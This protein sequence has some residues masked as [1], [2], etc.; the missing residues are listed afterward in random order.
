M[1]LLQFDQRR[2]FCLT[3]DLSEE[4]LSSHPYAILSHTWGEDD[5]EVSF[6]DL[7][8][9]LGDTKVGYEKLRFC[10][11]QAKK[12]SLRYFWVDTC[13]IDKSSSAELSKAITSMFRWYGGAV[14]CYVYLRDVST[15]NFGS[16]NPLARSWEPA[17]RNSRWFQRGW[18]LQELLA[19]QSVEF[20][21]SH[22]TRLGDKESLEKVLHEV[23]KIPPRALRNAPLDE[24][25]VEE[26]M[27]WAEGRKT[28]HG[29]DKPY[30]LLG[31]FGVSMLPN[32]GEG[33]DRALARLQKEIQGEDFIARLPYAQDAP[34]NSITSQH[35]ATCLANTRVDLLNRIYK[36]AD[37]EGEQYI[38]WLSGLAGTG[39]TTIARSVS[40][41]YDTRQHLGASFFFSRGGGD[42]GR[43]GRF[44]TSVA[45]QLAQS[46]PGVRRH[47]SN[48]LLQHPEVASQSL[49]DQW[50]YLVLEPLSK[51]KGPAIFVL[52]IDAL[53]E[54]DGSNDTQLI[55]QLLAMSGSLKHVRLRMFLT[56]RPEVPI[57]YGLGQVPDAE[58]QDFLLHKVSPSIVDHDIRLFL[59]YKLNL[60]G[61]EDNQELGWPGTRVIQSLVRSASGLFIWAATACRFIS[62]GLFAEERLQMLTDGSDR[63]S[64]ASPEQHL[65][66]L[67][68]TVLQKS[69]KSSYTA[70]EL[71]KYYS[72]MRQILGSIIAL[73]SSLSV[74]SLGMLI[75]LP[76]QRV[77]RML[78]E[79]HAILDIPKGH[80]Q[81]LRLHHPSFRDFLFSKD[82]CDDA[83]FWID[84]RQAHAALASNCIQL[85]S[86]TLK[87]DICGVR[88]PGTLAADM[89]RDRVTQ[90]IQPELQYAC[91]NW[92]QHL[93]KGSIQLHEGD[94]VDLFL[95]EHFLHWLEALGWLGKV[96]E[97]I[98]ALSLLES[99]F[100]VEDASQLRAFV[101]DMKR[102]ALYGRAAVER[103]PLQVYYS[104]L[105]FTPTNSVVRRQ[106]FMLP[107][108][109]KRAPQVEREWNALLQTLEGH[110]SNVNAVVFS[111]DGKTVASASDDKTVKLWDAGTGIEQH[112]LRGHSDS[113]SA[114]V[115]SPD[116][117][118][119]A[120]ASWDGTVKLWD[121]GTG[122][123]QHTLRGHS[124][125][126]SAVVFS[127]DGKTVASASDDKT[128]KLWD[129]GT[130]TE[131]RTLQVQAFIFTLD[132]SRDGSSLITD[133]RTYPTFLVCDEQCVIVERPSDV[134]LKGN[135]IYRG[136]EPVIWLPPDHRPNRIAVY[137]A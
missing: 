114:V 131:L 61:K 121:A 13:C 7:S 24:F 44:V 68:L 90:C 45:V 86:S 84:E 125:S 65:N 11:K 79:L 133:G 100:P 107:T 23:T 96:S 111:P 129:A 99:S 18:T 112:T 47:I 48:A 108:W 98:H 128:V 106:F 59:E 64:A 78:K 82:R 22:G 76:E 46:V 19:P 105:I 80:G 70:R 110:S 34:F 116:G 16:I 32:Y 127:P 73:S 12:D 54:C 5:E 117:K 75:L 132:F 8:Q 94:Q 74:S 88:A 83:N 87:Q 67:Y 41:W 115:F 43:A 71:A 92:I 37:G 97:G 14:K 135:W 62:E 104:T 39:K 30:S 126:V 50:Q 55:V 49:R 28:T 10:E 122:T 101:H 6:A 95:K 102:F 136:E 2:G 137:V 25:S 91:I 40:R 3:K 134:A 51:L 38:F 52:V 33:V 27:A 60:I 29:E 42:V 21:D 103:A 120:S 53:D 31:L 85:M 66:Q 93:A 9:G 109:V 35:D 119:V 118:T 124:D 56:S 123:E 4:E 72:I 113:V 36:W 57:Q 89:K 81:P 20:F 77:T 58:R 1:R 69:I 26:R 63:D 130:G 15:T 17:F